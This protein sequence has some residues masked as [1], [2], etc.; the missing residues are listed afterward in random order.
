MEHDGQID[1]MTCAD[2]QISKS[3]KGNCPSFAK[4]ISCLLLAAVL[5]FPSLC[6]F[7]ASKQYEIFKTVEFNPK[8]VVRDSLDKLVVIRRN[9]D[10]TAELKTLRVL[11]TATLLIDEL[12]DPR[13]ELIRGM[14]L[15]RELGDSETLC[16]FLY[17][18][19]SLESAVGRTGQ[20]DAMFNEAIDI[21]TR[22]HLE[23]S[24][25]WTRYIQGELLMDRGL[26]SAGMDNSLQAYGLFEAQHDEYGMASSLMSVARSYWEDHTHEGSAKTIEYYARARALLD[27]RVY[28]H[29]MAVSFHDSAIA[30]EADKNLSAARHDWEIALPLAR[31]LGDIKLQALIESGLA[32][33]AMAEQRY[34]DA[35]KH[36]ND[37]TLHV[38]DKKP[39]KRFILR[40]LLVR[41]AAYAHLGM[42]KDSLS[43]LDSAKA[44]LPRVDSVRDESAYYADAAKIHA[45]LGNY[46]EAYQLLEAHDKA[47]QRLNDANNAKLTDE[48]KVRFDVRMKEADNALLR[49]QQTES[50]SKR[51]VLTLA[52]ALSLLL[53]AGLAIH[54]R[55]RTALAKAELEHQKALAA[56]ESAANRA[57]GIF[58]ANMS[59]ELRSPLNAMLGFTQLLLRDP[60]Q[61]HEARADLGIILS[62][63]EHLYTL[64]NQ[65]LNLSKIEAG[66]AVI[67]ETNFDLRAVLKELT[68]MFAMTAAHKGLLLTIDCDAGV[69]NHVRTDVVKLRQVLIN[70][71]GN[72]L[73]FTQAGSVALR[74]CGS[75]VTDGACRLA[76]SVTDTGPGIAA[77]D[78]DKLG[79]AFIQAEA[80]RQSQEGTGLGLAISRGFIDLMGGKLQLSSKAG[81]GTTA[82]FDIPVHIVDAGKVAQEADKCR[83]AVSLA[84]GQPHYRILAVD[85]RADGRQLLV[86]LLS[87]MG[88]EVHEA[89]NG[90]EAIAQ[91]QATSPHLIW[92][93]MRMPVMDGREATRRIKAMPGGSGTVII[94]LTA[95]SYEEE[96]DEILAVGCDDFLSKPFQESALFDLLERHLGAVFIYEDLRSAPAVALPEKARLAALPVKLKMELTEALTELDLDAIDAAIAK[97][98]HHDAHLAVT[99]TLLT[100][101]YRYREIWDLLEDDRS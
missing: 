32:R 7:G 94:A 26:Y 84:P 45:M 27:P 17:Y 81:Q 98:H 34:A 48:L 90:E 39:E 24:L 82:E 78:I 4:P 60:G 21:A 11:I 12:A 96:R 25:A 19:A 73:K 46:H 37:D 38:M 50:N 20:A 74:I 76:F 31:D 86:R 68:D 100:E 99:L 3:R 57:K 22:D 53:L 44:I 33:I 67:H 30:N 92:M 69:P 75:G 61:S 15:A 65:I 28:R 87:S 42:R 41:A 36:L 93:D 14:A 55:R 43:A 72:A 101:D 88:F 95:S 85:D 9:G 77:D 80:G 1:R 23:T 8:A 49:A 64:I 52:L 71:M 70:L 97:V 59:H 66:E 51:I 47:N 35:L 29:F 13:S 5:F 54:L 62:S 40:A 18:Y 2:T 83:R 10:K 89:S 6:V 79:G 56:A 16:T 91:W 63:G 58:L